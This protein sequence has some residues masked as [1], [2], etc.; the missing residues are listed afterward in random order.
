MKAN[1]K[2][3]STIKSNLLSPMH[4]LN[5]ASPNNYSTQFQTPSPQ[6]N[7]ELLSR[8]KCGSTV[9]TV[10]NKKLNCRGCGVFAVKYSEGL[11]FFVRFML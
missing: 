11:Y 10:F 6:P 1:D 3:P 9:F 7:P 8:C 2:G 4:P 5:L